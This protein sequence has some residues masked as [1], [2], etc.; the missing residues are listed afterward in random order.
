M[1]SFVELAWFD[2]IPVVVFVFSCSVLHVY[3]SIVET[4]IDLEAGLGCPAS[5]YDFV[6]FVVRELD[7]WTAAHAEVDTDVETVED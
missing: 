7:M 5:S 1:G 6:W 2:T 4:G 3:V